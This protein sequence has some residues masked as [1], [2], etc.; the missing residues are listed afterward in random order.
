LGRAFADADIRGI[1]EAGVIGRQV[2]GFA[3]R[4]TG[5]IEDQQHAHVLAGG[6]DVKVGVQSAAVRAAQLD[7]VAEVGNGGSP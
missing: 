5:R 2:D 7:D 1:G 4:G 3:R 6:I